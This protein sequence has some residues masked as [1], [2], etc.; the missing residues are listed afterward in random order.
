MLK[1]LN[2]LGVRQVIGNRVR[3][4]YSQMSVY[5]GIRHD[6]LATLACVHLVYEWG[7]KGDL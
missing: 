4:E 5:K 6:D 1:G 7:V 3:T 2:C